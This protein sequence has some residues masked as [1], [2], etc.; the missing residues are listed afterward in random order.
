M[1]A[2]VHVRPL[3]H[4]FADQETER[5]NGRIHLA[6]SLPL[7]ISVWDPDS[8]DNAA[9]FLVGLLSL[10]LLWQYSQ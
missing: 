9:T 1:A 10:W 8:Q 6:F 4:T 7:F 5:E 2:G 3:P